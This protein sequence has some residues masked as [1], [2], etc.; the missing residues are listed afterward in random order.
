MDDNKKAGIKRIWQA[1]DD[2]HELSAFWQDHFYTSNNKF[3][4][5]VCVQLLNLVTDQVEDSVIVGYY[6]YPD[7][8][9]SVLG[10]VQ[11]YLFELD[12]QKLS[13]S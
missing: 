10:Q 5:P 8:C 2:N 3:G 7:T 1:Q 4:Y 6:R 11:E 9:E 12:A 13:P